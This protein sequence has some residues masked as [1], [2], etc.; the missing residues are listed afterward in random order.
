MLG[1]I[2]PILGLVILPLIVSFMDD[3]KWYHIATLYNVTIPLLVFY[4]GKNILSQ[5]PTGYGENN[6]ASENPHLKK[7]SGTIIRIGASELLISPLWIGMLFGSILLLI[8]LSPLLFSFMGYVDIGWGGEDATSSCGATFC[9]LG[10]QEGNESAGPFGIGAA[11]LSL[12]IP[13][14]LGLGIGMYYKTRSQNLIKVRERSKELEEEFAGALFQL[15]NRLGDGIPAENAVGKVAS[16]MA[17]TTSGNFFQ[18]VDAN[19]RR[20]GFGIRDAIFHPRYGALLYYPSKLIESSMKV[21]TESITKGPLVAAQGLMNISR[22]IKEIHTVN[23]RLKDLLA[24]IISSMS[25]Q[26]KFLTPA[27]SGIV[28]GI[29]S[30]ISTIMIK[31]DALIR[32]GSVDQADLGG[33]S[34]LDFGS[35]ISA[36]YF[37]IIVGIYVVQITWI[38]TILSN[39][40]ENGSD[41]LAEQY[42]MGK[43]LTNSTIL[44]VI[45]SL[46]IMLIF[47]M[48]AAQVL[49]G[50][51]GV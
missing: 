17:G 27:I 39:G 7:Y 32:Q 37:Q 6:I 14:A 51:V 20:L 19:I 31:L 26:I 43:N 23:E 47:N 49:A 10:F 38:L 44:Y 9:F 48:I 8:G 28:V 1:V 46:I 34:G 25:S 41:S 35:G 3:V 24:E 13:L 45:I 50:V 18:L 15:G 4:L 21:L 30:M 16:M 29:T 11:L 22:Y 42:S 40:V 12:C 2:L 5:R 36:Y 33:L